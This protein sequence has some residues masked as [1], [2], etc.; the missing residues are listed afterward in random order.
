[1]ADVLGRRA[2]NRALLERQLLLRRRVLSKDPHMRGV[3]LD[4]FV[5]GTWKTERNREKATLVIEPFEPLM[6]EDRDALAEEG[7]RLLTFAA[8]N[9]KTHTIEFTER[10]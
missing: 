6:E 10:K 9:A 5:R 2:L 8:S 3:L 4:G 1:M 7:S